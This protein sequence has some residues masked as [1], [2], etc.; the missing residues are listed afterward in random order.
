MDTREPDDA[1]DAVVLE[2]S[3][4]H[5]LIAH[6]IATVFAQCAGEGL[7]LVSRET[8]IADE[9]AGAAYRPEFV[10]LRPTSEIH[11]IVEVVALQE[12]GERYAKR[13]R[14]YRSIPSLESY[15]I[16]RSDTPQIAWFTR[17]GERQWLFGAADDIGASARLETPPVTLRLAEIYEGV[18]AA[19][20]LSA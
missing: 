8:E 1:P 9:E 17:Y 7:R 5:R 13:A 18:F 11:T 20:Q 3:R 15:V 14:R 19:D 12:V 2:D 10:L 6:R 4:E 16:A